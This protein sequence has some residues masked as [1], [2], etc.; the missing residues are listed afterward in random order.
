M[1][2]LYKKLAETQY[3]ININLITVIACVLG[4]IVLL[5]CIRGCE[6]VPPPI[7]PIIDTV[8]T[9]PYKTKIK[10]Q[11]SL[12]KVY[13]ENLLQLSIKQEQLSQKLTQTRKE[14]EIKIQN[15]KR[16]TPTQ[17]D[18]FFTNRYK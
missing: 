3:T 16:Y 1:N 5:T 9:T 10:E 17:L 7:I 2:N 15:I 4:F 6:P 18:S 13:E 14:Y 12:I 11:D 8:D